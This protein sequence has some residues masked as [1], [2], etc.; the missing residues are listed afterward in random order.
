MAGVAILGI[1]TIGYM[2]DLDGQEILRVGFEVGANIEARGLTIESLHKLA[3][4][5]DFTAW[6]E[7]INVEDRF[8]KFTDVDT[9]PDVQVAA[10]VALTTHNKRQ[11]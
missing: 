7:R 9:A 11:L 3:V 1:V 4:Y 8:L 2:V 6:I 5:V 10:L